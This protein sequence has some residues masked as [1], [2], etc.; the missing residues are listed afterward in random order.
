MNTESKVFLKEMLH[1]I[2]TRTL[3]KPRRLTC[4]VCPTDIK[5]SVEDGH[6]GLNPDGYGDRFGHG[7]SAN[8]GYR[9]GNRYLSR[10]SSTE[11]EIKS[12]T[13]SSR[14]SFSS[15]DELSTYL[16]QK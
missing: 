5:W 7:E 4:V 3:M 14:T 15:A 1:N 10:V 8:L 16:A 11:S 9:L 13:V 12:I 2:V 6:N